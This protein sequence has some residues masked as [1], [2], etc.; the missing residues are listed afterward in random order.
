VECVIGYIANQIVGKAG[1]ADD[2]VSLIEADAERRTALGSI[3]RPPVAI[4]VVTVGEVLHRAL[5]YGPCRQPI[6][7]I[8]SGGKTR[9]QEDVK[10]SISKFAENS[11]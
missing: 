11:A 7:L 4:P 5:G 2:V 10:K 6:E 9:G 8:V 3:L 1:C